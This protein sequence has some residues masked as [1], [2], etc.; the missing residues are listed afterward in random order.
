VRQIARAFVVGCLSIAGAVA[1]EPDELLTDPLAQAFGAAPVLWGAELSPD[2]TK[3]VAL[4]MH[5]EGVTFARVFDLAGGADHVIVAG[6]R[7][8]FDVAWCDW[9]SD[10][11]LL[12]GLHTVLRGDVSAYLRVTR[13]VA[14]NSDGSEQRV[15]LERRLDS[16]FTQ[17]QDRI[18][19]WL[20][21]EPEHVLVQIPSQ[22]GSG[23]G[24]VNVFSGDVAIEEQIRSR[25]YQWISDGHG[26]P[27]LHVQVTETTERWFARD[28]P[29]STW[30]LL[31]EI[32][33]TDM[34]SEFDPI[35]FG[36]ARNELL[37][38]DNHEG[39]TA[40]FGLDLAAGRRSRL[41]YGHPSLDV[42]GAHSLGRDARLVAARYVDDRPRLQFFDARVGAIHDAV[43]RLFPDKSIGVIDEDWNLL[44]I[45]SPEDPGNYYRFDTE[46]GVLQRIGSVYP[47]LAERKLAPMAHVAYA[48]D[49]GTQIP[50]YLSLPTERSAARL[51][52]V[53]LP[54]G[55]PSARDYWDYD[56][57]VQFLV[58]NG[59]A[60]L[61][62]NYRGSAGY[63]RAWLGDGGFRGW[64]RAVAD[65]RD[66]ARYLI[67]EGIADPERIC[68]VG[69]SYGG[70]A[71]LLGAI[72]DPDLYRCIASIAGVTDPKEWRFSRRNYVG[73]LAAQ[74]F[75]GSDDKVDVLGSPIE[76]ASE[77]HTPVLLV[78]GKLDV[79]VPFRQ[80][81]SL[82]RAL[83]RADKNVVFIEYDRAEHDIRPERYR[84]DMLARLGAFLSDHIGR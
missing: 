40:L 45:A 35:G 32:P 64:R 81:S 47:A 11:R 60:V 1:A 61:Q 49:D 44:F 15:L 34:D 57:L 43:G 70:Y 82:A 74:T 55:G 21:D 52:A 16:T 66:G 33:L 42:A 26:S 53:I 3:L 39:R 75:V 58:A 8:E 19:D 62:S 6:K 72:E 59:Y 7:D 67:D 12:C 10:T 13:L 14:V 22:D 30:T 46:R 41:I 27:R 76:R 38:L 48:A 2:G 17:F 80:S 37:Y 84:I 56:Y 28:A 73:G 50:A 29:D 9:K 25:V 63:G 23:V 77:I 18:V 20:P 24:R 36:A 54:H 71:A 4:Q 51:P 5:P 69:W 83:E 79:N 68:I 31:R 65:V 78:H